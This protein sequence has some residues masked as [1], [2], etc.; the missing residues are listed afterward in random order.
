MWSWS[1]FRPTVLSPFTT[2]PNPPTSN[3]S[4]L[5]PLQLDQ[6]PLTW[7]IRLDFKAI[8]KLTM[9]QEQKSGMKKIFWNCSQPQLVLEN[10]L[11]KHNYKFQYQP[12]KCPSCG[13]VCENR[14]LHGAWHSSS[15][16]RIWW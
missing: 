13:P 9:E 11:K 7:Q 8:V 12:A 10:L 1:W 15:G 2:P 3:V 16:Y 5:T 4:P 6:S 14:L